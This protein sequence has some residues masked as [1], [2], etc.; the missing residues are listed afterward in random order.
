LIRRIHMYLALF[1]TPWVLM[2]TLSTM[3]MN[4]REFFDERRGGTDTEY[5]LDREVPRPPSIDLDRRPG[6]IASQVLTALDLQ[7]ANRAR[8][9]ADSAQLVIERDAAMGRKRITVFRDEPRI[10]VERERFRGSVFL[11][12]LHRRRGYDSSYTRED[13]WGLSVDLVIV[14]MLFWVASG[15]WMWWELKATRRLGAAFALAGVA[16][17]SLFLFTI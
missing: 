13:A 17:F 15:L 1:L 3:A 16:L 14:A 6:Q 7:G 2:Y 8:P 11:E 4:H 10:V 9:S 12:R 5:L